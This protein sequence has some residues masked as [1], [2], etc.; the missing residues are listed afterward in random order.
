ML[1]GALSYLPEGAKPTVLGYWV[2]P[3]PVTGNDFFCIT[4]K[5][6][7]PVLAHML[8]NYLLDVENSKKNIKTI[9]YQSALEALP[10]KELVDSGLVPENLANALVTSEQ[11]VSGLRYI[12]LQPDV[13]ALWNDAWA[14]FKAG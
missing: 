1:V 7:R 2:P 13:D 9:G 10:A 11:V 3:T 14:K 12:S 5:S 6:A 8:V 4:R